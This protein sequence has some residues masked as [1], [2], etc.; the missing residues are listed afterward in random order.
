MSTPSIAGTPSARSQSPSVRV[1]VWWLGLIVGL[2]ELGLGFWA[3]QQ[4]DPARAQLIL[5]WVG[6]AAFFRGISEIA[7]AFSLRSYRAQL[8]V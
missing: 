5:L 8:A 6:F 4:L 3:S 2:F 7:T 1:E